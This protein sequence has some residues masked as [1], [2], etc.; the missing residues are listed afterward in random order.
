MG[1]FWQAVGILLKFCVQSA[2]EFHGGAEQLIKD[3]AF[4]LKDKILDP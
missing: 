4:L 1:C 3:L 2:Q